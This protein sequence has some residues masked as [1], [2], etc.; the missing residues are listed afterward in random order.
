MTK[1]RWALDD[2]LVTVRP[3]GTIL[4]AVLLGFAVLAAVLGAWLI[5]AV[6]LTIAAGYAGLRRSAY[7]KLRQK[8]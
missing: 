6:D 3:L 1:P 5:V 2:L 4:I 7:R 8:D